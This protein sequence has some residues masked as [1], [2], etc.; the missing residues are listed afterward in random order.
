VLRRIGEDTRAALAR[1]WVG[2]GLF[3]TLDE[4]RA[5]LSEAKS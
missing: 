3:G 4:A 5:L 2:L 1:S